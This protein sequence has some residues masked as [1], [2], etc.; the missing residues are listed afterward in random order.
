MSAVSSKL[1]ACLWGKEK[2]QGSEDGASD[3]E[4]RREA[5]TTVT[6]G[7]A[8]GI[9]ILSWLSLAL[10]FSRNEFFMVQSRS[11]VGWLT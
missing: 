11:K 7:A 6:A 10:L 1:K 5:A 2:S 3:D 8:L 4:T 9:Q